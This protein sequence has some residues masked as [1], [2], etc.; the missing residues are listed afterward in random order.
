ME[1]TSRQKST[2]QI[3]TDLQS[4][5]KRN[6]M[7]VEGTVGVAAA[8]PTVTPAETVPA[9]SAIPPPTAT[10]AKTQEK[11]NDNAVNRLHRIQNLAKRPDPVYILVEDRRL[12][13]GGREFVMEVECNGEKATGAGFSK[14]MAKRMAAE[15]IL[16]KMGYTKDS[17]TSANGGNRA[18][19]SVR[20][21]RKVA[22]KESAILVQTASVTSPGGSAGR[23]LMPGVLL[24]KSLDNLGNSTA[25]LDMY[26]IGRLELCSGWSFDFSISNA[27]RACCRKFGCRQGI[28]GRFKCRKGNR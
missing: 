26:S 9:R 24:M 3:A 14:R 19:S 7:L 16:L 13:R 12:S 15:S 17:E 10:I 6:H 27:A 8:A 5:L 11:E 20:P 25:R 28:I 18:T 21:L 1:R 23:Q 4:V 2:V 22:F